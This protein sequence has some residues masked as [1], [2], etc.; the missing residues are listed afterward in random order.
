MYYRMI[1]RGFL[2]RQTSRSLAT[3]AKNPNGSG[4][5]VTVKPSAEEIKN[6]TL[7]ARNLETAVRHMHRDG[8]VVIQD[9]VPHAALDT[10][11]IKM[12]QDAR[13]LQARGED[14]PFNYN[15]GNLQQDAPPVAKYF[16][17]SIFISELRTSCNSYPDGS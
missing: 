11:N 5:P 2:P 13:A 15:L 16:D 1:A 14:G 8:L 17:P 12:V 6:R 10:L 9:V 4:L 3:V 7:G